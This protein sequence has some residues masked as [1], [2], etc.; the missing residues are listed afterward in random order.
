MPPTNDDCLY[1][2]CANT[3]KTGGIRSVTV[4]GERDIR[5]IVD[6]D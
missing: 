5:Y 2:I 1:Y 6:L 4:W 3:E